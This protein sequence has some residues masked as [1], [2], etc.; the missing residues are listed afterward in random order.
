MSDLR[1]GDLHGEDVVNRVLEHDRPGRSFVAAPGSRWGEL[2]LPAPEEA[3]HRTGAGLRVLAVTSFLQGIE[4]LRA[5]LAYERAHPGRLCPVAVATDDAINADARIGLEKRV[6]KHYSRSERLALEAEVIETAL[7]A[8]LPVYTGE[9][10]LAWF[11]RQLA[12]WRPDA[13]IVCACGQI[14]DARILELPRL[15][16]YNFHPSDLAHGHGAGP[17]PY[18]D[19][20]ARN[21]PWTRW[22]V[23]RMTVEVDAGAIV[24]QSPAILVADARGRIPH[25]PKRFYEKLTGVVGPMVTILL[26]ELIR[27]DDA[28]RG[29]PVPAIDFGARLPASVKAHLEEPIA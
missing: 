15:G 14:F 2:I 4:V 17:Q 6:W 27:L 24:G 29:G 20:R 19:V 13:I 8:G 28:G 1:Q 23:H 11:Y 12:A 9:L 21:D 16:V 5:L 18:E 10:K 22:T 7:R 26:E 3:A 25:A